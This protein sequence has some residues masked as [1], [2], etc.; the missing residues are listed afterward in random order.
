MEAEDI[1]TDLSVRERIPPENSRLSSL[2]MKQMRRGI[3]ST[4]EPNSY[5]MDPSRLTS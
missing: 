1:R 5:G 3:P 2:C 4:R